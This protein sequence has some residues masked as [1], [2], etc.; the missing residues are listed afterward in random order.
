MVHVHLI[1]ESLSVVVIWVFPLSVVVVIGMHS[2]EV[3]VRA[4]AQIP[5]R[6]RVISNSDV[7]VGRVLSWVGGGVLVLLG[8][9]FTTSSVLGDVHFTVVVVP[10]VTQS[11]LETTLSTARMV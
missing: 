2:V 4:V 10:A 6:G 11:E 1:S 9:A 8:V 7:L 5:G 3:I